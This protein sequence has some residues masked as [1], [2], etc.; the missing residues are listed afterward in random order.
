MLLGPPRGVAP[1]QSTDM[2]AIE[3]EE[4]AA[5]IRFIRENAVKGITV[6][7]VLARA[8]RSPSTLERRIK[9]LWAARSRRRS[10]G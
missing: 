3:D 8:V 9:R 2:L 7:D 10:R 4:V 6:Q 5:A 1:R